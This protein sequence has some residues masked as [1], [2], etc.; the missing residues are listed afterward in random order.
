MTTETSLHTSSQSLGTI[1]DI[2][3]LH[4]FIIKDNLFNK[5]SVSDTNRRLFL[6]PMRSNVASSIQKEKG[7]KIIYSS[8]QSIVSPSETAPKAVTKSSI[9]PRE[10][11]SLFWCFYIMKNDVD[12]Y[13]YMPNRNVVLEKS[14]KIE[15]INKFRENKT[16]IKAN[17][18]API[19]HIENALLNEHSIDMRTFQALCVLEGLS[20]VFTFGNCYYEINTDQEENDVSNI[21]RIMRVSENGEREKYG[22]LLESVP[23]NI[24]MV[25][26][27]KFKVENLSKPIKA[28]TAYKMDELQDMCKKLNIEMEPKSKKKDMYE[29]IVQALL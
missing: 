1:F 9:I 15:Y 21:H 10:R 16:I 6:K 20:C 17:R 28:M 23:D 27:T 26:N 12:M 22:Y 19:S 13:E 5:E 8:Q 3:K 29:K 4:D 11:D 24:V 2:T 25:R 18:L 7:T 14:L